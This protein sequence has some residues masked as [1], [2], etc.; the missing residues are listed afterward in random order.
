MDVTSTP[1]F[2]KQSETKKP[3]F[4]PLIIGGA[5]VLYLVTRKK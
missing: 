1:T 3:N 5:A 4:L 2:E